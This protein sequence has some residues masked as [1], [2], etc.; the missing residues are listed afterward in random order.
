MEDLLNRLTSYTD[1]TPDTD[2]NGIQQIYRTD[3]DGNITVTLSS[4]GKIS[5]STQKSADKNV[6]AVAC[7][8]NAQDNN[9]EL[10][11]VAYTKKEGEE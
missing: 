2:A 11:Y 9:I 10:V 7:V 5:I 6:V 3:L 8:I 1:V 4:D